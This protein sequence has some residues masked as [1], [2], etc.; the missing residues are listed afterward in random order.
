M[1]LNKPIY[2]IIN[3]AAK[4]RLLKFLL[5]GPVPEMSER[6][7]AKMV[8]MSNVALNRA[9]AELADINLVKSNRV[10]GANVWKINEKSY[11]YKVLKQV[12]T[13]NETGTLPIEAVK[14]ELAKELGKMAVISAS[15]F[16][17]IARGDEKEGSDIDLFVLV[18]NDT[19]KKSVEEAL[20]RIATDLVERYGNVLM[21]YIL[22]EKEYRQKAGLAVI[23]NIQKE[24]IKIK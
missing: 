16:G 17:S 20:E 11:A 3:S 1:K 9:M 19:D 5:S 13:G 6:A 12:V 18:K 23:K 8:N 4:L 10:A 15:L 2:G 24:G 21:P 7:F 14:K 22:T